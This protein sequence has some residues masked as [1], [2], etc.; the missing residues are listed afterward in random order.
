MVRST[1]AAAVLFL[2]C[3]AVTLTGPTPTEMF[4]KFALAYGNGSGI[5]NW[6]YVKQVK[7]EWPTVGIDDKKALVA[8]L[9]SYHSDV[10]PGA[11]DESTLDKLIEEN[12]WWFYLAEY[13]GGA[14]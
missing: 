11:L 6:D 8:M 14:P 2:T 7:D 10:T 4:R 5:V 13:N 3:D 9:D 1:I 12:Y